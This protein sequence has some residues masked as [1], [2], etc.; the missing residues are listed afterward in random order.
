MHKYKRQQDRYSLIGSLDLD[1]HV[2]LPKE[3]IED[4]G[5][6]ENTKVKLVIKSLSSNQKEDISVI[7]L[8]TEM[9]KEMGHREEIKYS[10]MNPC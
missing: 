8:I 9:K 1:P 10:V 2:E 7:H 3:N 5:T 6:K 4:T